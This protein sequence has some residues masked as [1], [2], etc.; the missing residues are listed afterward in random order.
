MKTFDQLRGALLRS[1][2]SDNTTSTASKALQVGRIQPRFWPVGVG[3][4][5]YP[6]PICACGLS[7]FNVFNLKL[8]QSLPS[9]CI[10]MFDI[11][12]LVLDA[13]RWFYG[14]EPRSCPFEAS[15]F[16]L[17]TCNMYSVIVQ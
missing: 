13:L 1:L 17:P 4:L 3:D 6:L 14:L 8:C 11:W 12:A 2:R 5:I 10:N 7:P 15:L 9:A 16:S